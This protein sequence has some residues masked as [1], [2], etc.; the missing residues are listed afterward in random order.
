M[1]RLPGTPEEIGRGIFA[2]VFVVFTPLFGLHFIAAAL[3]AY[4]MRGRILAALLAT[5]VGNPLTYFP[6]AVISLRLGY[7]LLDIPR[8]PGLARNALESFNAATG[9][10]WHN[11]KALFTPE[12][13]EWDGLIV[14]WD[15]VFLP[16]TV[17][18]L[19]P[20]VFFGLVAYY[21]SVPVL[22][23]YQARRSARLRKKMEKLRAQAGAQ[24]RDR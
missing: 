21:L 14:F 15:T 9:D 18:G 24:A 13:A 23:A 17:G 3:L 2:G 22:R 8:P 10:L 5:F 11:F 1:R 7:V 4:I 12:R 6:I 19:L 16:W 20:G